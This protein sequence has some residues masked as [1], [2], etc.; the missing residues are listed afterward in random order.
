MV[1]RAA[2]GVEIVYVKVWKLSSLGPVAESGLLDRLVHDW[3]SSALELAP[4][5]LLEGPRASGKSTILR[6][7]LDAGDLRSVIDLTDPVTRQSAA[8]DPLG[9]LEALT[10]PVAIDEV[11]LVPD[12]ALAVKRLVD[13]PGSWGPAVLTGSSPVARG[14]LGGS[15][16]LVGRAVRLRLRPLTL[17]EQAGLPSSLLAALVD[18][19]FTDFAR[20]GPDRSGYID[21]ARRSGFP[22]A[23]HLS[24]SAAAAWFRAS[25][26]DGVLP[27]ALDDENRRVNPALLNQVLRALAASPAAELNVS[28]LGQR[29]DLNRHTITAHL[30]LLQ[31]LGLI[32]AVPGWRLG[33]SKRHVSRPK[34]HPTDGALCGWAI[35]GSP[36]DAEIGGMVES[37]VQRELAAQVDASLGAAQLH[38]WRSGRHEVDLVLEVDGDFVAFEVKLSRSLPTGATSGMDAL[39]DVVGPRLR[40]GV[41][42]YAGEEVVPLAPGRLAMPIAALWRTTGPSP[43]PS[44][45]D[46]P[47]Q[48][49]IVAG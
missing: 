11:Q 26:V 41:V 31:D 46:D 45:G 6:M 1:D 48:I 8:A 7:L 27:R 33:A 37:L 18:R 17:R 12:L 9:F 22:A 10:P 29:L 47:P 49:P 40:R 42:L 2:R 16:P 36:T 5:V 15:D 20:G 14:N 30:G 44:S 39:A 24:A 23:R 4:V 38:H 43:A 13:R 34:V 35:G 3:L 19:D 21:L 25:Y 32:D 28:E